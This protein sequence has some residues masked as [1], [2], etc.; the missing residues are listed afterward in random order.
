MA[1]AVCKRHDT[2]PH[3]VYT[4]YL[5]ELKELMTRG[6]GKQPPSAEPAT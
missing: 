3:H 1:A 2:T 5:D 4:N 6:V